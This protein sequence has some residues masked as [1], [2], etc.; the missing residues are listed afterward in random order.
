MIQEETQNCHCLMF[1]ID[2]KTMIKK[3]VGI[4]PTMM[5]S[6]ARFYD[7]PNNDSS[8]LKKALEFY[9]D[10]IVSFFKPLNIKQQR[11]R[12]IITGE[13]H[14][15]FMYEFT[16]ERCVEDLKNDLFEF[17]LASETKCEFTTNMKQFNRDILNFV[18]KPWH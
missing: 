17:E 12:K 6:S 13:L 10:L 16:T 5:P 18:F 2:E 15:E 3:F 14:Y 9:E 8:N 7:F 11:Y 4:E 1:R